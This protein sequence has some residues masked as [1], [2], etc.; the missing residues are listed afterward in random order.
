MKRLPSGLQLGLGVASCFGS[1][2]NKNVLVKLSNDVGMDLIDI[3][4]QVCKYGFMVDVDNGAL[5]RF[6]HDKIEQAG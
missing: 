2:I 4:R 6:S 1:S 5:F 3:L